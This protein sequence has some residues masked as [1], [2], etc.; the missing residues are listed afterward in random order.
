METAEL[1]G[2]PL[3]DL[4]LKVARRA[5]EL[6]HDDDFRGRNALELWCEAEREVMEKDPRVVP[7]EAALMF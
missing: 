1:A 7:G 2:D 6:S 3:F 4:E 5:D